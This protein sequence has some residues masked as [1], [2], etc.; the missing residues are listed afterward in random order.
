MHNEKQYLDLLKYIL[1]HGQETDDRTG[2]GTI[3]HFGYQ[4]RFNLEESFP[5]ITTKK[6]F[7][8]GIVI[9]L[10]WMLRGETNT[11]FLHQ[12]DVKIWDAWQD[13]N[14]DL[15]PVYGKQMRMWEANEVVEETSFSSVTCIPSTIDQIANVIREIKRN[16]NSRRLIVSM[17]NPADL[18]RMALPPCPTMFQFKVYDGK[19]SCH[20]Y[21]RSADVFLGVPFDIASYALLTHLIANECGLKAGEF[22]VSYGDVHIYKNHIEQVKLQL[23]RSS[24]Q[25]PQVS[26]KLK[27]GELLNFVSDC[28]LYSW[29]LIS[30]SLE[31]KNYV[32][33]P[34]IKA[35]VAV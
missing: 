6:V 29:G 18:H 9:E 31:I 25:A 10:L 20:L 16:P 35:E 5:L 34:S 11:K 7:W 13:V 15:G 12:Y 28:H 2:V 32:S 3:S 21:Q 14:G 22:I 23:K 30:H 24:L 26:I 27:A 17:W 33:H 19:L 4:L 1:D 8:K